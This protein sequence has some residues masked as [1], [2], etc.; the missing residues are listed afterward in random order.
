MC[1]ITSYSI[2]YTKLY[3]TT[4]GFLT[5]LYYFKKNG[6]Q[7]YRSYF[8]ETYFAGTHMDAI[9]DVFTRK[10]D[11]GVAKDSIFERLARENADIAKELQILETVITSYSIHYTKL[12]DAVIARAVGKSPCGIG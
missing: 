9:R 3:E 11:I 4:A 8:R 7:D 10:A 5:A 1:V 6:V 2:H 12:Y